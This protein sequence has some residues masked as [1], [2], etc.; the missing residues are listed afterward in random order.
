[1]IK[2]ILCV[3][4]CLIFFGKAFS[5]DDSTSVK[6]SSVETKQEK[7]RNVMLNAESNTTPRQVNVGLPFEGDILILQN[8]VPV[9][10]W[11]WPTL[12][13][14]AWRYDNSLSDMGL[15]SFSETALTFGKVGY[16]IESSSRSA[17]SK[18]KG[19]ATIYGTSFGTSRY[20]V[21]LT[22]P[23]NK[24]GWGYTLSAYQ[25]FDRGNG[26]NYM[27]TTW[28]NRTSMLDLGIH[29]K[30]KNGSVSILYKYSDQKSVKSNYKPLRYLGD[31][32]TEELDNFDLGHDSYVVRDGLVPYFD[33]YTGESKQA[34]LGSD[35]F[36]RSKVHSVYLKGEHNFSNGWNLTYSSMFQHAKTP[37]SLELPISV[38]LYEEDQLGSDKYYYHGTTNEYSGSV[39][40]TLSSLIPQSNVT[41]VLSRAELTKTIKEHSLRLGLTHQFNHSKYVTYQGMYVQTVE[42]NP[43]ILDYYYYGAYDLSDDYGGLPVDYCG[44]G[45]PS[46]FKDNKFAMYLSDDFKVGSR[47]KIGVGARIENFTRKE[48]RNIYTNEFI[49]DNTLPEHTFNNM[50]NEVGTANFVLNLTPSFGLLGDITYNSWNEAYWDYPYRD[51]NGDPDVDPDD[52]D[53]SNPQARQSTPC[54]NNLV[55]NNF[56]GGIF[57]NYN[58]KI[59]IVSK[60]NRITKENVQSNSASITNPDG[61]GERK[62]FDPLFYDINTV[63]WSTDVVLTPFKNF[64]LHYLLTLQDP[65]FKNYEYSAFGVTYNY[66]DKIIPELSKVLMEIDP[67]Y[68]FLHGKLRCW[69]SLRYYGKQYANFTN[70]YFYKARWEN[71][72][73]IDYRLNRKLDFKLQ[74]TNFL[75][76]S[77]VKGKMQGADQITDDSYEGRSVVA[78]SIRPQTIELSMN[79]KF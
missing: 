29:K 47:L 51:S 11:Y 53:A 41:S 72:G 2:K 7:N 19:Y 16:T 74:V 33:P 43:E 68:S 6:Q 8:D 66:N 38:M 69:F 36:S 49:G 21:T 77:G 42:A 13:T 31:G 10:Y 46:D 50:W 58:R 63:G 12:P 24:K 73:G 23:I 65:K 70:V 45:G 20:D 15:A 27:F 55:V 28:Y 3:L 62:N 37:F 1:M 75:N 14:V 78:G 30:Y 52:Y 35:K 4:V 48:I 40:Y 67:S 64:T 5:Q 56:G 57:L 25:N 54:V 39:Q 76:E 32:E 71:F 9:V 22:G 18:F 61:S 79:L 44:Y 59:S 34:N 26:T 17:S 60:V